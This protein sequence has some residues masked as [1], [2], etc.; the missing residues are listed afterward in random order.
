MKRLQFDD[1]RLAGMR[2]TDAWLEGMFNKM[3]MDEQY[4]PQELTAGDIRKAWDEAVDKSKITING[5]TYGAGD[6]WDSL[7]P[8][9]QAAIRTAMTEMARYYNHVVETGDLNYDRTIWG[10][11]VQITDDG[12]Q[13]TI[14]VTQEGTVY[15]A[16]I[17]IKSGTVHLSS[18][19]LRRI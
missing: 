12:N 13:V 6:L 14:A 3:Q 1:G 4:K 11:H 19:D 16:G 2:A 5:K 7:S 17:D 10:T 15:S 18:K 8:A 9:E